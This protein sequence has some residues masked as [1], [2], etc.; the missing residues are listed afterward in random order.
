MKKLIFILYLF[1]Q[2]SDCV[3]QSPGWNKPN[4]SGGTTSNGYNASRFL[5]FPTG[6]GAP[7]A[8]IATTTLNDSALNKA[9][10]YRDSCGH[11]TYVYDPAS[12]A[13]SA[14]GGSGSATGWDD[15]LAVGQPMSTSR[16]IELSDN[17]LDVLYGLNGFST[18][19]LQIYTGSGAYLLNPDQTVVFGANI[20]SALILQTHIGVSD[21]TKYKPFGVSTSGG[22][23]RMNSWPGSGGGSGTVTSVSGL[24]TLFTVTNPTTT[25]TF[26]LSNAGAKTLFGRSAGIGA[27]SYLTSIDSTWIP[28]LHSEA[29]YNTKYGSSTPTL[30]TVLAAGNHAPTDL[31]I[32]SDNGQLGVYSA[33]LFGAAYLYQNNTGGGYL[34]LLNQSGF[35]SEIQVDNVTGS[36][37][38]I[39][40]PNASGT[41]ALN[42]LTTNGDMIYG[43]G[44][45]ATRLAAGTAA[46]TLH[47]GTVPA[48]KDTVA[49][50]YF[51]FDPL[52][53][54][55]T[56]VG[57][58]VQVG[59]QV[60]AGAGEVL[61]G[62]G[63]TYTSSPDIT[64]NG[65]DI[66]FGGNMNAG[67]VTS[68]SDV[69]ATGNVTGANLAAGT[70]SATVSNTTNVTSSTM[71]NFIYSRYGNVVTYTATVTVTTTLA[72]AT[73][74][75]LD[76]PITSTFTDQYNAG[77]TLTA[78]AAILSV[79]AVRA[80]VANGTIA[81][82]FMA[83]SVGGSGT[84]T[85]TGQY[86]IL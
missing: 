18:P 43:V 50:T 36:V 54:P 6:C 77:G 86:V 56:T 69:T 24:S 83:L 46:Q 1:V 44:S 39:Q 47:G 59:L 76:L 41:L 15:M 26:V 63:S 37:K 9:A 60:P 81:V 21:T 45:T 42:P 82:S 29:Y 2:I 5:A 27:P 13:W 70:H 16:A 79:P 34:G 40:M 49:I 30:T 55:L 25:P 85:I 53:F 11:T 28:T 31:F 48:W 12:K 73:S 74:F 71:R 23:V 14:V 80:S 61:F 65:F 20:D 4:N 78:N 22:L 17:E 58:T 10:I 8:P 38:A 19:A 84:I 7:S 3:A 66:N 67:A 57:D 62:T 33:T 32:D 72:I 68:N 75:E 35:G 52:Y 64:T 51:E